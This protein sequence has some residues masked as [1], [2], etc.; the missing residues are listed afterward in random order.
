MGSFR[1]L[2][3]GLR[4]KSHE[5]EN[6]RKTLPYGLFKFGLPSL[7]WLLLFSHP[8][9]I[10]FSPSFSCNQWERE[11]LVCLSLGQHQRLESN[12]WELI[13]LYFHQSQYC[14]FLSKFAQTDAGRLHLRGICKFELAFT[15]RAVSAT[16]PQ[17]HGSKLV[18]R[19]YESELNFH[20]KCFILVYPDLLLTKIVFYPLD[21]LGSCFWELLNLISFS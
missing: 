9:V 13:N 19:I 5:K 20:N 4:G 14:C 6:T 21:L 10:L 2:Q 11:A 3:P 8:Q 1:V 12:L 18:L 17:L 7:I 15:K 16:F